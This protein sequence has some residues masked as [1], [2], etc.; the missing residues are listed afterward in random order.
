MTYTVVWR[1]FAERR[2]AEI[3]TSAHDRPAVTDAADA[4][5]GMLRV[6]PSRVGESRVGK[7]RILMVSPLSVY[8]DVYA[9]DR[10]VA[11]W[12]V[13]RVRKRPPQGVGPQENT[14]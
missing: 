12:D 6:E 7:T 14:S 1:P 3:W 13:W 8:Y 9:D 2:L 5:D 10:L 4:I 11:V